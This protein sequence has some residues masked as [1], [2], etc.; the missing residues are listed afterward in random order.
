M[1]EPVLRLDSI[2]IETQDRQQEIVCGV[3]LDVHAG[4]MTALVGES[5]SG[6][7]MTALSAIGL[8]PPAVSMIDGSVQINRKE[9]TG[10]S[11]NQWRSIRGKEIAMVFQEPMTALDPVCT[12]GELFDEVLA[13]DGIS[14]RLRRRQ[15]E[16]L[17]EEVRVPDPSRCLKS[18]PHEISGGMR[19]RVVIALALARS[20]SILLADEP[21]TALDAVTTSAVMDLFQELCLTRGLGVLLVTHDL[22]LVATRARSLAVLHSG[23]VCEAGNTDRI[24][25]SP[26]HPYTK[27]LLAC[28][29]SVHEC[30]KPLGSLERM[31]EDA[32][33]WKPQPSREG[34]I[35]PWKPVD[36][37]QHVSRPRLVEV[38]EGH[39]LAV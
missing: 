26:R 12:I 18:V 27:G 35:R 11:Q 3:S 22:G 39:F 5:G 15:S 17:L 31:L 29:L 7:T 8:L 23:N 4:E 21:T 24:L 2:R 34:L 37:G 16:E 10:L 30:Q 1:S 33:I 9:C 13:L 6:K 36:D 28:R 20:P 25:N 38:D 14:R 32:D 19:Q